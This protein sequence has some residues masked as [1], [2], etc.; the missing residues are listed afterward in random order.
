MHITQI[1]QRGS[2]QMGRIISS[3][4]DARRPSFVVGGAERRRQ[5]GVRQI[6]SSLRASCKRLG[7]LLAMK[8]TN[9]GI[10]DEGWRPN[11][12][13]GANPCRA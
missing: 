2:C 3:E 4:T 5:F 9:G 1:H 10:A 8:G 6:Y 13:R 7:P 11:R 12:T